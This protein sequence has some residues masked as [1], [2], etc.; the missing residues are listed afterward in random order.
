MDTRLHPMGIVAL[1]LFAI[2]VVSCTEATSPA[3]GGATLHIQGTVLTGVVDTPVTGVSRPVPDLNVLFA[4]RTPDG[5]GAWASDS[6]GT[7]GTYSIQMGVPG[8]CGT[9]DSLEAEQSIEG[10]DFFTFDKGSLGGS[11]KVACTSDVQTMDTV[12]IGRADYRTPKAVAG[13]LMATSASVGDHYACATTSANGVYCWG[14][15]WGLGFFLTKP[16]PREG[17][18]SLV[19]V[20][21]NWVVA[22][23]LDGGGAAW[24]W[25][26]NDYGQ[27]GV[28]D[29]NVDWSSGT[30]AVETNLRF[31]QVTTGRYQACGLTAGGD[32]YCWGDGLT[33]GA[34]DTLG[35]FH[36]T[37]VR[38]PSDRTF[39][40]ISVGHG[41]TCALD[42]TGNAWCWGKNNYGQLGYGV[43]DNPYWVTS[44]Q[45]VGGGHQFASIT[46]GGFHTCGLTASGE[47]WCW[48]ANS[49]GQLGNGEGGGEGP[50]SVAT[51]VA[52]NGPAFASLDAGHFSTC[53]LTDAGKAYCWGSDGYAQLGLGDAPDEA[54]GAADDCV[55][56]PTPVSADTLTFAKLSTGGG[57][58]CGVTPAGKLYCWGY[59]RALGMYAY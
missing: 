40:Q 6:T 28:S 11:F 15:P 49:D 52:V 34:G 56:E 17:G 23:G 27:V 59:F 12:H 29:S 5:S 46:A 42:D 41:H 3:P 53:G 44:P 7:D 35:Y 20:D 36:P 24:C 4:V 1:L 14:E 39:V 37:P 54:C 43:V 58:T 55:R 26:D 31:V 25:G 9:R 45:Q 16:T 30:M 21:A 13:G 22:C 32:V 50:D 33:L 48:G 19:Q 18:A 8:G 10:R 51:P 38:V 2:A 47:A 57:V